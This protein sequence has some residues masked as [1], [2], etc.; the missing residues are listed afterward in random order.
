MARGVA[1]LGALGWLAGRRVSNG[2]SPPARRGGRSSH[3]R[4]AAPVPEGSGCRAAGRTGRPGTGAA[5]QGRDCAVR[6]GRRGPCAR[7]RTAAAAGARPGGAAARPLGDRARA[8]GLAWPAG[9]HRGRW[10][11]NPA[12]GVG[13]PATS[14][15]RAAGDEP[16]VRTERRDAITG[17]GTGPPAAARARGK[18][19]APAPGAACCRAVRRLA[20]SATAADPGQR[21]S[22]TA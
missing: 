9:S 2:R 18:V 16:V 20:G 10:S 6:P 11:R 1:L 12:G 14:R 22:R 15:R 5:R 8:A 4:A 17:T 21:G 7:T 19:A 3:G 13:G